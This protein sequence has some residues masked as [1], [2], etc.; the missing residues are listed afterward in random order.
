MAFVSK[1][2]EKELPKNPQ[3]QITREKMERKLNAKPPFLKVFPIR[4][5]CHAHTKKLPA[6]FTPFLSQPLHQKKQGSAVLDP[7]LDGAKK[8]ITQV[9]LRTRAPTN[10]D[11]GSSGSWHNH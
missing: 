3:T 7:Q 6:T 9:H 10:Q 4:S 11:G 5:S 2:K 8:P 1:N